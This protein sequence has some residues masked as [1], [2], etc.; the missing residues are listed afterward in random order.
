MLA[1]FLH[2]AGYTEEEFWSIVDRF[3]N[4]EILEKR[5]G[6]W[7]LKPVVVKALEEGGGVRL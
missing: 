7:Q 1:D 4:R 6:I 3:A 5:D 2:F